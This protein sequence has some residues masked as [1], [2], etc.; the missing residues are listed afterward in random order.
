MQINRQRD[1][2]ILGDGEMKLE[3]RETGRCFLVEK[4]LTL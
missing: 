3:R 2:H 4:G 1:K